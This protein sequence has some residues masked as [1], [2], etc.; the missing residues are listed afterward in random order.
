M[1]RYSPSSAV[2]EAGNRPKALWAD[3]L[4]SSEGGMNQIAEN[5]QLRSGFMRQLIQDVDHRSDASEPSSSLP[6]VLVQFWDEGIAM[7]ADV[8]EC[9]DSWRPLQERGFRRVLFDDK[10]A[11]AFIDAKLGR[12]YSIAF[13]RCSHPAM[14]ADF[15][16]LCFVA[17][18]GGFYVDADEFF[19]GGDCQ[20]L[21]QDM[22]LKVQPLCYDNSAGAM[23]S[24]KI[25]T[26]KDRTSPDWIFYAN[27]NP[28]VAPPSHP[29][30]LLALARSTRWL[31]ANTAER[32]DIQSITG[33]GNLTASLVHHAVALDVAGVTRDFALLPDWEEIAVSRWPLEYRNDERNWR[34]WSEQL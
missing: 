25:F 32:P 9:V 19:L 1:A 4:L 12:P 24:A 33:P 28:L 21:F 16:R 8:R 34:I 5:D 10:S 3:S 26:R 2:S 7:P 22:R 15:F 13:E 29:V 23:V 17:M 6:K 20:G 31:L 14:R 18:Q 11:A 27:N 30:I